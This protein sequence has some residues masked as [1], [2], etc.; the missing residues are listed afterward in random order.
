MHERRSHNEYVS[1]HFYLKIYELSIW[2]HIQDTPSFLVADFLSLSDL[3]YWNTSLCSKDK[4]HR[5]DITLSLY[6]LHDS[7]SSCS[8]MSFNIDVLKNF[9]IFTGKLRRFQHRCFPVYLA[10]FLTIAFL[11]NTSGGY[12]WLLWI[13]MFSIIL[14]FPKATSISPSVWR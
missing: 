6:W 4:Q 14:D 10:N 7:K 11:W 12:F 3:I 1:F 5:Q 13:L 9:P 8:Q 2:V